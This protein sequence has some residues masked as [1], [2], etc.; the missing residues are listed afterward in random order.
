MTVWMVAE[1]YLPSLH[2]IRVTPPA[3]PFLLCSAF[4]RFRSLTL[5]SVSP[6]KY[7]FP[8]S[9]DLGILATLT[10]LT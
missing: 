6:K 8:S 7:H 9:D 2:R 4:L 10:P 1:S 3:S 5:S